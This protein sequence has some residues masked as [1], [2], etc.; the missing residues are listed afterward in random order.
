MS[1][2][3]FAKKNVIIDGKTQPYQKI[4]RQRTI[5]KSDGIQPC[6]QSMSLIEIRKRHYSKKKKLIIKRIFISSLLAIV[7]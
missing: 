4:K 2:G 6:G 3:L 1:F 5:S 7:G